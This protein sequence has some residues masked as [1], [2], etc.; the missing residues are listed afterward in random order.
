MARDHTRVNLDIWGDDDFRD[1]PVDSQ[2][3]YWTLWTS[4]DRT[5]CGA[6]E[7][8]PGKLSQCAEDWTLPRLLT[9]AT[10]LSERLFVLFDDVTEECL[11]RSWIKHDGLWRTPNLAVTIAN[12][13]AAMGSKTL[14]GVV[15]HEVKK[16]VRAEPEL[17]GWKRDEVVKMLSQR[18]VDPADI[19]PYNP[20]PN[21]GINPSSNPTVNPTANPYDRN[22]VNPPPNPP[23]TTATST[24]TATATNPP[25]H[26]DY[27]P[28]PPQRYSGRRTGA[29]LALARFSMIPSH[30]SQIARDIVRQYSDSL[31]T[32]IDAKTAREIAQA[33]DGG[34]QAG[35]SPE[36][37]SAGIE[38]W[39]KSDSFSPTQIAKYITKAAARR[40]NNGV[41]KPTLKAV[42]NGQL[43]EELIAEM[44]DQ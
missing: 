10:V 9:A 36:A 13:R 33:V 1:L 15:V 37:I 25:A 14:R 29:E 4:P 27:E 2:N 28:E 17:N 12:A 8:R 31:D 30:H 40:R 5:Y 3:L 42:Q 24:P 35:Q 23:S 22:G 34:I 43:A 7:W 21:G 16:L 11:I 19:P 20:G 39:A 18:D 32:P 26:V 6:H 38:D 41:G 44:D